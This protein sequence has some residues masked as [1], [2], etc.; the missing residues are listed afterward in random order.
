M[1]PP[2]PTLDEL[3]KLGVNVADWGAVLTYIRNM[4]IPRDRR[5]GWL[6]LAARESGRVPSLA[7]IDQVR[8]APSP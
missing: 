2:T 7:E 6:Q 8:S 5:E 3:R 1:A 4:P